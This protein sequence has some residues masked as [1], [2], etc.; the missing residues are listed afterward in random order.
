MALNPE[1]KQNNGLMLLA[2]LLITGVV[3]AAGLAWVEG[4]SAGK[5]PGRLLLPLSR[6]LAFVCIGLV[7]AQAI[8]D[9]GWTRKLG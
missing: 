8:D 5:L 6:M 7:V 1:K 3:L 2:G 9:T 4:V